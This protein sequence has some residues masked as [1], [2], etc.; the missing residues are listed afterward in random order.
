MAPTEPQAPTTEAPA[1]IA[2]AAQTTAVIR[3]T[4][5]RPDM[6]SVMGPAIAEVTAALRAQ[7]I[8]PSGPLFAHH[9][10]MDEGVFDFEVGFPVARPVA[11]A[12]RVEPG[13]LPAATVVRAIHRG[14][15]EGLPAAWGA[16]RQ[17]ME[18]HDHAWS[19]D[20][21]EVYASGPATSDDPADWRTELVQP[22]LR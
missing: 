18:D 3:I 14:G 2:V 21:W 9:L 8:G 20:L 11:A 13:A 15:Y 16:L 1:I 5:P 4:V 6:K 17:W 12:G 22:L 19:A 10:R 7:G